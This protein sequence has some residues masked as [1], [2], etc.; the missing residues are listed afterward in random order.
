MGPPRASDSAEAGCPV[1]PADTVSSFGFYPG[2]GDARFIAG[3]FIVKTL[4]GEE[5]HRK[6]SRDRGS[7]C[8]AMGVEDMVPLKR[9]ISGYG[10]GQSDVRAFAPV[11]AR[12]AAQ[13]TEAPA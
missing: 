1:S 9:P 6:K 7:T 13:I 8:A 11:A 10:S 4:T 3:V 5:E 2:L 12:T